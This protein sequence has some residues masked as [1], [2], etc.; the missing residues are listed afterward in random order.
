MLI[1]TLN[2]NLPDLTDNL[3]TQLKRDSYFNTHCELMVLDN[4][5][6]EPLARSTT[7]RLDENIFFGG[8]F[9]VV[10]DYFLKETKHEWLYFLNNDLIFHGPSF[11]T[12]SLREAKES[13]ASIYSPTIINAS[14]E[15]CH[16]KQM[17]NWGKGLREVRWIDFQAPLFRRDILEE[18]QQF[19]EE[20][21]YGWG[22][23][24]YGGCVAET[25]GL[26][27]VV[28]DTNTITHM[29]SLTFKENKVNIG[30]NEFCQRAEQSMYNYFRNSEYSSLYFDLRTY[31]EQYSL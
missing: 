30:V 23:D 29:N 20:L 21:I 1:A 11:L 28:S 31:G 12:T 27:I 5:S 25:K 15:Q 16:W 26:K 18:I 9:N 14:M 22:T 19:P 17:W 6:S 3:V 4:G 24:F 13:N 7:H 10:L 8:G 2:H